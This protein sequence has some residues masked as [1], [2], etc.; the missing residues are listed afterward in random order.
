MMGTMVGCALVSFEI[1]LP[2]SSSKLSILYVVSLVFNYFWHFIKCTS[3]FRNTCQINKICSLDC[4][5]HNT[6]L[7]ILNLHEIIIIIIWR[8]NYILGLTSNLMIRSLVLTNFNHLFCFVCKGIC[9][10]SNDEHKGKQIEKYQVL[11]HLWFVG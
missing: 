5:C 4:S 2:T 9:K 11:W 7:Y 8:I 3:W 6:K 1:K 10:S